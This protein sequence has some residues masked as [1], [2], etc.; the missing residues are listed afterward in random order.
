MSIL[1]FPYR[2]CGSSTEKDHPTDQPLPSG[3]AKPRSAAPNRGGRA[4]RGRGVGTTEDLGKKET[5]RKADCGRSPLPPLCA[6]C[7]LCGENQTLGREDG[8]AGSVRLTSMAVGKRRATTGF[9]RITTEGTGDTE[10]E[11]GATFWVC[12]ESWRVD[13]GS[14]LHRDGH[15]RGSGRRARRGI[16]IGEIFLRPLPPVLFVPSVGNRKLPESGGQSRQDR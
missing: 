9:F 3:A 11:R 10:G 12:W 16:T 2:S 1:P 14:G 7:A 5:R 13:R 8:L 6:L 4:G 15:H